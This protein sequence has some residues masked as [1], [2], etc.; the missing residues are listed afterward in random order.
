MARS[1]KRRR[2]PASRRNKSIPT[3]TV[4]RAQREQRMTPRFGGVAALARRA[5]DAP[6]FGILALYVASLVVYGLLS[7]KQSVPWLFPDEFIYG[8]V[9]QNIAHGVGATWRGQGQGIPLLYPIVL[10]VPFRIGSTVDGYGWAKLLGVALSSAVV[11]P[12][13][14]LAR[15]LAGHRLALAAAALSVAGAWMSYSV[16]LIS[17]NL[18]LPLAT[19]T[20]AATVMALRRPGSRWIWLAVA[21]LAAAAYTRVILFGLVPV[22]FGALALDVWRQPAG[23][24]RA[25]AQLHRV[26][27]ALFGAAVLA[28]LVVFFAS[29]TLGR[30]SV[31]TFSEMSVGGVISRFAKHGLSLAVMV[32]G[33]PLVAS[34]GLALRRE[35]W[36]DA[37]SGPFL[38]VL[39]PALVVILLVA[40]AF[41]DAI[42]VP[43][44]IE[45]YIIYLAPLTFVA[46]VLV[47]GRIS[48]RAGLALGVALGLGLLGLPKAQQGVEQ[49]A[50][51]GATVRL[52]SIGD[53]FGRHPGIWVALIW[54][55]VGVGGIWLL[56][57][58]RGTA[59][60]GA[61]AAAGLTAVLL[62][63]VSQ[64][65]WQDQIRRVHGERVVLPAKLDFVERHTDKRVGLVNEGQTFGFNVLARLRLVGPEFEVEF[66]NRNIK[67]FYYSRYANTGSEPV[68]ICPYTI[69]SNGASSTSGSTCP[70]PP[71]DLLDFGGVF[72]STFRDESVLTTFARQG[73]RLVETPS[74]PPRVLGVVRSPCNAAT[75]TGDLRVNTWLDQ[76]GTV[77]VDFTAAESASEIRYGNRLITLAPNAH[78][79]IRV[80]VSRGPQAAQMLVAGSGTFPDVQVRVREGAKVTR[81]Y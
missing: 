10:S 36:R 33:L 63:V 41:G 64:A 12:V 61:L 51:F 66:F 54:T 13:W 29:S 23:E 45:R 20:L 31:P 65:A 22:V 9:A 42:D 39:I 28:G 1:P 46:L 75:C 80:P 67:D 3:S 14:M 17:E 55:A 34:V 44:P 49:A 21:F 59:L 72:A 30:Y 81:L 16:L 7:R 73:W 18:A 48:W 6:W 43:W 70:P 69:A 57:R 58:R 5:A 71:A 50:I 26:P 37:E 52:R 27:L 24:R 78:R 25:R 2:P 56:T 32:G 77:T 15:E 62:V 74:A 60:T 79:T 4:P 11:F 8:N 35:N 19:A 53:A 47:P 38:A 40:A 68:R 76:P